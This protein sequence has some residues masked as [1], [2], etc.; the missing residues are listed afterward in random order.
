MANADSVAQF[1]LDSF[2]QGRVATASGASVA[3]VGNA[4]VTLPILS[5]G[6]TKGGA[7]ANSGGII[8]RRVTVQNPSGSVTGANVSITTSNDGN[9]SNAV[10]SNVFLTSLSA[11]GTF[12]DL[13]ISGGNVVVSGYTTQALYLNVHNAAAASSTIDVRVYG[14]VINF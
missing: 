14:D 9:L 6:L 3:T 2:G 1:N 8:V 10:A 4:V 13:V 12:Q 11:T 7:V 5:G